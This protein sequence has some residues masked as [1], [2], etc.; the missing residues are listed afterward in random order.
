MRDFRRM[1]FSWTFLL[2]VLFFCSPKVWAQENLGNFSLGG[3]FF[4]PRV[5]YSES[6]RAQLNLDSWGVS[7]VW[8]LPPNWSVHLLAGSSSLVTPLGFYE[9][10]LNKSLDIVEYYARYSFDGSRVEVGQVK[11]PVGFW[12]SKPASDHA[13]PKS[14][15]YQ[16]RLVSVRDQG[17]AFETVF[18]GFRNRWVIHT[19]E[20]G[21][22]RDQEWTFSGVWEFQDSRGFFLGASAQAGR[23]GATT[24]APGQTSTLPDYTLG[25]SVRHRLGN[26][27]FGW[28]KPS[29][30]WVFEGFWGAWSPDEEL[31]QYYNYLVEITNFVRPQIPVYF[32]WDHFESKDWVGVP[33]QTQWSLGAG[34]SSPYQNSLVLLVLRAHEIEGQQTDHSAVLSWRLRSKPSHT[35]TKTL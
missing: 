9:T 26:L 34:L 28:M 15:I 11:L 4:H 24:P 35:Q 8:S 20:S 25:Q 5:E 27:Y 21:P 13:L 32:R 14:L 22:D 6:K 30:L 3:V 16:K 10:P 33:D 18:G 7:G 12:G 23:V 17:L 31:R 2:S 29:S 1:R 19:G